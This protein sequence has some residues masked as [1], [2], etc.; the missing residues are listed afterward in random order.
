MSDYTESGRDQR[1]DPPAWTSSKPAHHELSA[2]FAADLPDQHEIAA[3]LL[4]RYD[5]PHRHHHDRRHLR[6]ILNWI[7]RLAEPKNDLFRVRLAGWFHDAVY[8]IVP[9]QLTNE[10]ASA[11]LAVADLSRC[12]LEQEDLNEIARLIRLTATH[13]A[14]S[15]DVDGALLCDADLAI[16]AAPPEQY[17]RY[18]ADVRAEHSTTSDDVFARGRFDILASLGCRTIFHTPA[19]RELESAAQTNLVAEA[20][21]L[22]DWLGTEPLSADDWPLNQRRPATHLLI[23]PQLRPK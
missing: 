8:A 10:E 5:E 4:R 18:V 3:N 17:R 12:G 7:E 15:A 14:N 1:A 11:R 16:L 13:R 19:G 2:R 22:L 23:Y 21:E 20:Y 9:G 6:A